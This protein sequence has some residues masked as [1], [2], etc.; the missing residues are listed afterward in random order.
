MLH[1]STIDQNYPCGPYFFFS[2]NPWEFSNLRFQNSQ[3]FFL[4]IQNSQEILENFPQDFFLNYVGKHSWKLHSWIDIFHFWLCK[5]HCIAKKF[6]QISPA[7]LLKYKS[8]YIYIINRREAAKNLNYILTSG[9]LKG[10]FFLTDFVR[11]FCE[12][13][14]DLNFQIWKTKKKGMTSTGSTPVTSV[15][16]LDLI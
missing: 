9:F 8:V 7:A 10:F 14:Q 3:D 11:I 15:P 5:I 1:F 16:W 12:N 13:S 4:R 2:R 6:Q